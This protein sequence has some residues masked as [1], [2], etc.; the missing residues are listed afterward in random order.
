MTRNYGRYGQKLSFKI[1]YMKDIT[2]ALTWLHV[3]RMIWE[4]NFVKW[5]FGK[6]KA[7]WDPEIKK[8]CRYLSS[9]EQD[10]ILNTFSSSLYG[11]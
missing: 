7:A 5:Q 4:D 2:K 9:E 8:A 6:L 3:L 10:E 11:R 1:K